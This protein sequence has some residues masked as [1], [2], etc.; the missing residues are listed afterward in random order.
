MFDGNIFSNI[1]EICFFSKNLQIV[2]GFQLDHY[3]VNTGISFPDISQTTHL[4]P[5]PGLKL[6]NAITPF[7]LMTSWSVEGQ[8]FRNFAVL[9][10]VV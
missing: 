8:I 10:N 6:S 9:V 2:S 3:S 4:H 1:V 7:P 5:V